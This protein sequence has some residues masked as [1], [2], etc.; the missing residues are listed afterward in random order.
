[1]A[2][3]P[4]QSRIHLDEPAVQRRAEDA[5]GG[6]VDQRSITILARPHLVFGG[7]SRTHVVEQNIAQR[8]EVALE[9]RDGPVAISDGAGERRGG[10]GRRLGH[11]DPL[12]DVEAPTGMSRYT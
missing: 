5:V 8:G 10:F 3:R 2:E 12:T 7:L 1:M 6:A 4:H 9:T 11:R